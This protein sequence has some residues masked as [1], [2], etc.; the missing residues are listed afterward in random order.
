MMQQPFDLKGS[1]FTIPMLS[2]RESNMKMIAAQLAEKVRQAPSFFH[3]APV[4]LNLGFLATPEQIDLSQLLNLVREQG[5]IPAGITNCTEKQQEQAK[6][7]GLAVL[8]TRG[9]A[10][11]QKKE[12]PEEQE[13]SQPETEP[14]GIQF[15]EC[16][17]PATT[18]ISEPIRSGQRIIVDKGDLIVLKSVGS[19]AEVAAPGN[20]HVYGTLRGRAFAGNNGDPES[21]IFCQQ[22]RA[23]LVAIA[24]TYL[25]NEKFP[26]DLRAKPVHI[27]LQAGRIRITAL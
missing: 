26:D 24:G 8:T 4:V 17:P 18:V 12:R 27:Q 2:L 23:E 6:A 9:S 13:E 5:F 22:L 11:T 20:I 7:L 3:D 16:A 10:R 14:E 25:V 15:A 19:G 1:S 21:R